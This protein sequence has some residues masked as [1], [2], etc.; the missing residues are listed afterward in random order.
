MNL[1]FKFSDFFIKYEKLIEKFFKGHLESSEIATD[2]LAAPLYLI[3]SL[4]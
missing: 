2:K 4:L 1:N 3:L